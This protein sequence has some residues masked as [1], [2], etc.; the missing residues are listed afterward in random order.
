[1]GDLIQILSS[2][3]PA[4][5]PEWLRVRIPSGENYFDLKGIMRHRGLHTVCESAR[6][7]NIGECWGH[8]TATF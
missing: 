1:M 6:C 4:R 8:R 3:T 5:R 7:P 2:P